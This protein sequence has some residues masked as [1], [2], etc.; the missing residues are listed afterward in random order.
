MITAIG[1]L[2]GSILL[3]AGG[4]RYEK[5]S[6]LLIILSLR[7]TIGQ[8]LFQHH[9]GTITSIITLILVLIL[10][11]TASWLTISLATSTIILNDM[12][13]LVL[14]WQELTVLWLMLTLY[15]YAYTRTVPHQYLKI[16]AALIAGY[17]LSLYH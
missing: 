7:E 1:A 13:S 10:S 9:W 8:Q 4:R 5:L 17:A 16:E 2:A 6:T 12:Y 14:P 3:L 15:N 11:I